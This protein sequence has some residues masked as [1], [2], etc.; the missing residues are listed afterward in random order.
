MTKADLVGAVAAKVGLSKAKVEEVVSEAVAEIKK[1]VKKDG[2]FA[3]PDFGTFSVTKRKARMGRNPKTG[4]PIQIKASK[5]VKFKPAPGFK[6]S[7]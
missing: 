2:R 1:G 5:S 4:A 3:Y 6:K 7:L